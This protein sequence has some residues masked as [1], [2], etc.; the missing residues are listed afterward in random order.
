MYM[1]E[2]LAPQA[3][4]LPAFISRASSTRVRGYRHTGTP[5][6]DYLKTQISSVHYRPLFE[7]GTDRTTQEHHCRDGSD[8]FLRTLGIPLRTPSPTLVRKWRTVHIQVLSG[9]MRDPRHAEAFHNGVS[10]ANKRT[11]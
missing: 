7:D 10:S 5:A 8:R 6:Q 9:R 11:G 2:D 1:R 4:K 3:R